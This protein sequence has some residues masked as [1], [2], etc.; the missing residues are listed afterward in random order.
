[1]VELTEAMIEA[2]STRCWRTSTRGSRLR[3]MAFAASQTERTV[4]EI[5]GAIPAR[6]SEKPRAGRMLAAIAAVPDPYR[7]ILLAIFY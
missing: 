6:A 2:G 3:G 7:K 5:C 1:M 4:R